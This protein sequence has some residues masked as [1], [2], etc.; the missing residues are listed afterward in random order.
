MV[1][2]EAGPVDV[3]VGPSEDSEGVIGAEIDKGEG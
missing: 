2:V 3:V 1:L